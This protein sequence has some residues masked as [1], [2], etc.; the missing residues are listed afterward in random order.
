MML[1]RGIPPPILTRLAPLMQ[2]PGMYWQLLGDEAPPLQPGIPVLDAHDGPGCRPDASVRLCWQW[3]PLAGELGLVQLVGGE[4]AAVA[5]AAPVL[6]V[7][8]P[9]SGAWLHV[10][11][12]AGAAWMA[13]CL[14]ELE[15]GLAAFLA[16]GLSTGWTAALAMH[17]AAWARHR[18]SAEAY[19]AMVSDQPFTPANPRQ[20]PSPVSPA[21]ALAR[22]LIAAI[23]V[24]WK[25]R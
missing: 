2:S 1:T 7:L 14:A 8:A 21:C 25:A 15:V 18:S 11:D 24:A 5:A 22:A 16:Q 17:S 12:Q 6:D 4:S 13:A 19:L 10:G 3:H 23:P 9:T 20:W